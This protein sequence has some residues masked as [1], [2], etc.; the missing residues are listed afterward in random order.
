M[1]KNR[2][3]IVNRKNLLSR[4]IHD[5]PVVHALGRQKIRLMNHRLKQMIRMNLWIHRMTV[6]LMNRVMQRGVLSALH[7]NRKI[8]LTQN[9]QKTRKIHQNCR[10]NRK[11]HLSCRVSHRRGQLQTGFQKPS[12]QPKHPNTRNEQ[13]SLQ[14]SQLF[15]LYP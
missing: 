7:V 6:S 15:N 12:F 10:V 11:I 2:Q 9:L 13:I 3:M 5:V 4:V 14:T 1:R 8:R